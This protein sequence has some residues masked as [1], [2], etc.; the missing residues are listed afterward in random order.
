MVKSGDIGVFKFFVE[1]G[2][3]IVNKLRNIGK[4]CLY[5]VCEKGYVDIC[6]YIFDYMLEFINYFDKNG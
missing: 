1:V 6:K 2:V 3:D 5:I 4:N